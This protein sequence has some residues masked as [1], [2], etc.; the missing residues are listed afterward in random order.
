MG[1]DKMTIPKC[2]ECG[3][4]HDFKHMHDTAYGMSETHMAG[5][6]RFECG[7]CGYMLDREEAE[8][9]GLKYVLD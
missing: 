6:E 5:S 3:C 9:F 8:G 7:W 4:S 2:P 1:K